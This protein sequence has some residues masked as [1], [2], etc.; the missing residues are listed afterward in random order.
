LIRGYRLLH[1]GRGY[2]QCELVRINANT[3]SN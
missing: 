2:L 1:P 3:T